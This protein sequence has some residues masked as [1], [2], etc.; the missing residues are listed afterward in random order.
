M[1]G[2]KGL[3]LSKLDISLINNNES[4][5]QNKKSFSSPM[6]TTYREMGLSIGRDYMRFEGHVRSSSLSPKDLIIEEIIG[7]GA[8]SIVKRA[9]YSCTQ[10]PY[11]LKL[12][13]IRDEHRREMLVKE[14]SAM[15]SLKYECDCLVG[16]IGA[17]YDKMD[18][19]V[20]I[21]LEYMDR[22]SLRDFLRKHLHDWDKFHNNNNQVTHSYIKSKQGGLPEVIISS[23]A[24]QIIWGL[25]Y[26]HFENMIHRDVKPENVLINSAGQIKLSDFG[27]ASKHL[28]GETQLNQTVVGTS[29]YMSPERLRAKSY[30]FAS[31]IWSLGLILFECSTGKYPFEEISSFVSLNILS[32]SP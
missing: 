18:G 30:S 4:I 1:K 21:A 13:P 9:R 24:H 11:A 20:S 10:E 14:L 6:G 29:R 26:L 5:S 23:I 27:L 25:G 8:C 15:C 22:G 31:D 17:F 28:K 7:R 3:Q 2:R 19:S 32:S 12:F 16:L